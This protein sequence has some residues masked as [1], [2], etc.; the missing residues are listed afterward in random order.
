MAEEMHSF[1]DIWII[2]PSDE[3]PG[4]WVAHSINTDQ[5]ALGKSKSEAYLELKQVMESLLDAVRNDPSIRLLNPAPREV[6]DMLKTA[7]MLPQ[8]WM[9]SATRGKQQSDEEPSQT[10]VD[11]ERIGHAA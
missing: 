2:Y 8:D 1:V 9:D 10:P 7:R 11:L 4:M 6:R 3:D 5:I